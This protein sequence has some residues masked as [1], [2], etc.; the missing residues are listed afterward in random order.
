MQ[1]KSFVLSDYAVLSHC[2]F[3][4]QYL[5]W[6]FTFIMFTKGRRLGFC[7]CLYLFSVCLSV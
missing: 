5:F 1:I 3:W 6:S 4:R 7:L 2:Y